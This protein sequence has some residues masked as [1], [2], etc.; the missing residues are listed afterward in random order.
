MGHGP[1]EHLTVD[2]LTADH[3]TLT[4]DFLKKHIFQ[5][6]SQNLKKSSQ[7]GKVRNLKKDHEKEK[8]QEFE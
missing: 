5:K 8:V 4:D 1:C 2:C 3:Q 7:L 6:T